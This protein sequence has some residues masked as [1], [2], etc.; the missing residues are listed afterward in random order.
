MCIRIGGKLG[1]LMLRRWRVDLLGAVDEEVVGL[2]HESVSSPLL[3]YHEEWDLIMYV[4]MYVCKWVFAIAVFGRFDD[5]FR[6][7]LGC[8]GHSKVVSLCIA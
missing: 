4:C 2:D 1:K 6:L 8:A 5:A 3:R 7:A